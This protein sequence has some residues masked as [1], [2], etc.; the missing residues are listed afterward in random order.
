[1][2]QKITECGIRL[3]EEEEICKKTVGKGRLLWQ[4]KYMKLP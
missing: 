1:M 4:P 2:N 3:Y